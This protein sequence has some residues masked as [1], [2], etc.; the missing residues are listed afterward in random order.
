[1]CT[2][3]TLLTWIS[4]KLRHHKTL[5][6]KV[7]PWQDVTLLSRRM[8]PPGELRCICE[9]YRWQRRQS[10]MTE[11]DRCQQPLLVWPSTLY[12]GG[13]ITMQDTKNNS[14]MPFCGNTHSQSWNQII[15]SHCWIMIV[16]SR[17]PIRHNR[18]F[19]RS[20]S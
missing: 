15:A 17:C 14:P 5:H 6:N 12:T 3:I 2:V 10:M 4:S 18:S 19:Q 13:P 20:Y 11:D 1:M 9:C 8:L 7:S 16:W